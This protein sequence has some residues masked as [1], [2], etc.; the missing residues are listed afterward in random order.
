MAELASQMDK[1]DTDERVPVTVLI[2]YLGAG[3]TTLLNRILTEKQDTKYAVIVNEFGELGIDDRL[4]R[5]TRQRGG[6][7]LRDEQRVHLLYGRADLSRILNKLLQPGMKPLDGVIVETTG[8]ADPAPVAQTF[9][10]DE[11]LKE[12]ARS[13][14]PRDCCRCQACSHETR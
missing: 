3:K 9:F 12:R 11:V 7:H 10:V 13:R 4:V 5:R 6:G 14:C 8:L 1:M 2:G